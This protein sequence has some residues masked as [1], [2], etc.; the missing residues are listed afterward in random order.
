MSGRVDWLVNLYVDSISPINRF[1]SRQ[2]LSYLPLIKVIIIFHVKQLYL[3][4]AVK[5]L[6]SVFVSNSGEGG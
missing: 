6:M 3:E 4:N 2:R 1:I 5:Q